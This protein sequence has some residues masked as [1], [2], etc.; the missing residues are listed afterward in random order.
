VSTARSSSNPSIDGRANT[1][2]ETTCLRRAARLAQGNPRKYHQLGLR[3][4]AID[5]DRRGTVLELGR[6]Q[7]ERAR[8][9]VA[10]VDAR[11]GYLVANR[12]RARAV[13]LA[14]LGPGGHPRQV[15]GLHMVN[16]AEHVLADV[17]ALYAGATRPATTTPSRRAVAYVARD[18]RPRSWP[19]RG[20]LRDQLPLWLSIRTRC[21]AAHLVVLDQDNP[22][23]GVL[24]F[25]E[26]AGPAAVALDGGRRAGRRPRTAA[27]EPA[28]DRLYL[29]TTDTPRAPGDTAG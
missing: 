18:C 11:T 7:C 10:T 25:N 2:V 19:I 21:R 6:A 17:G 22:P 4:I 14:L 8:R 16:R 12:Q 27:G 28:A 1:L 9:P 24:R 23:D 13:A 26:L 3:K 29:R 20:D 15:V 5:D